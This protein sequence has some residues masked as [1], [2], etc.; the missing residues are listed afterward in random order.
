VLGVALALVAAAALA[1]SGASATTKST[2]YLDE[3]GEDPAGPDISSVVVSSEREGQL[4]HLTFRMSVPTNLALTNDMRLR[5]WLDAD[6]DDT[7]GLSVL[8]GLDHFL[9]VDPWS[10]GLR[11]ALLYHCRGT[12]CSPAVNSPFPV[13]FAYAEGAAVFRVDSRALDVKG[14]E[15]LEFIAQVTTNVGFDPGTG[16]F[17]LANIRS[18]IAPADAEWSFDAR[19][20]RVAGFSTSPSVP[21]AGKEFRL[22]LS[23]VETA[24]DTAVS[25]GAIACSLRIAGKPIAPR[26]RR[27]ANGQAMCVFDVPSRARGKPYRSTIAVRVPGASVLRS[28]SETVR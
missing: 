27:F 15:R 5:I 25:N 7:T 23:A 20:L 14:V 28:L 2:T 8:P 22:R 9:L 26:S 17:D 11:T 19:V 13:D 10:Y 3:R 24:T 21:R 18:D 16:R 6:S 1:G 4:T 12:S